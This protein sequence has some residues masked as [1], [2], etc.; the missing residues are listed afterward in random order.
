MEKYLDKVKSL[1]ADS[2]VL[3]GFLIKDTENY[4]NTSKSLAFK[5]YQEE[6]KVE[7]NKQRTADFERQIDE[8]QKQFNEYVRSLEESEE[9][10]SPIAKISFGRKKKK[11]IAEAQEKL[12]NKI[13]ILLH[14][15]DLAKSDLRISRHR[16]QE[17]INRL[18]AQGI[19][20]HELKRL[21]MEKISQEVFFSGEVKKREL[22]AKKEYEKREKERLAQQHLD[23]KLTLKKKKRN[24]VVSDGGR[25]FKEKNLIGKHDYYKLKGLTDEELKEYEELLK[26]MLYDDDDCIDPQT[27]WLIRFAL[28]EDKQRRLRTLALNTSNTALY[29]G[30]FSYF[31]RD[32]GMQYQRDFEK[33]Y[34]KQGM[35]PYRKTF[36]HDKAHV[37]MAQSGFSERF[38]NR[39]CR[40][41]AKELETLFSKP[42]EIKR[43][44]SK[45]SKNLVD[46]E[47]IS[48]EFE[49][50]VR[51][52]IQRR[53]DMKKNLAKTM[54]PQ[55]SMG[56]R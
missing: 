47:L 54:P 30:I 13:E 4:T 35:G 5:I 14:N 28:L 44:I 34:G 55:A 6:E 10:L 21:L 36:F 53:L 16:L 19:S 11:L 17:M 50:E 27:A 51:R 40:I 1:Q 24:I 39:N 23:E 9:G 22:R 20:W 32:G 56:R 48:K 49:N 52:E 8:A 26:H 3:E 41:Y 12:N 37:L 33:L 25:T 45:V 42:S 43:I 7:A 38:I 29:N 2:S 15:M 18:E 31:M 46:E